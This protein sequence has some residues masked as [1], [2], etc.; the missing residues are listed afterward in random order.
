MNRKVLTHLKQTHTVY[1]G[2]NTLEGTT[3][4]ACSDDMREA[5]PQLDMDLVKGNKKGIYK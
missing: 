1:G 3:A 5:K 2:M 4:Q